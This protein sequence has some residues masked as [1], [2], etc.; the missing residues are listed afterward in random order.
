MATG[1]LNWRTLIK[2]FVDYKSQV[3]FFSSQGKHGICGM[4]I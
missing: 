1:I 3:L 2:K 4:M